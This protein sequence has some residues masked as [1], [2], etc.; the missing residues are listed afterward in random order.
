MDW[1]KRSTMNYGTVEYE[2]RLSRWVIQCA[3]HVAIRLKRVFGKIDKR[4]HDRFSLS[5]T[6]ENTRDLEWFV[7]RY[8]MDVRHPDRLRLL[9]DEHRE[10]QSLVDALLAKRGAIP[11]FELALPLRDYQ[12]IA[13]SLLLTNQYLLLA[14]EVGLG[15]TAAAIGT[16]ADKRT[17]P[18]LV[19]TLTHLPIQWRD[20]IARFAPNLTVHIVKKGQPYDIATWGTRRKRDQPELALFPDVVIINYH[21]LSGWA[22]T[23]APLVNSI[24]FDECQE[25]R[26]SDS[27][28]Y[29]AA[30]HI[31]DACDF[32]MGLSATPIYNYGGE[33]WNVTRC[34][35][36]DALG[37][38]DEFINEWC[39][40]AA[41]GSRPDQVKIKNPL[42][43]GAYTRESGIM[44]RR[45]RHDVG[46]ELPSI[47][48]VPYM[49]EAD[50]EALNSVSFSCAE[51]AKIVLAQGEG[52]RGQKM[53]ASEELS[54]KLRQA[55][56][57]A[58]APYVAEFVRLLV[59]SGEQIVL[60][61]WHREVYGIW[62][63]R[64]KDL[65]PV[66]Y[67]GSETPV[68]KEESK[69]KFID[70]ESKVLIISLRAG[71]GLDGLQKACRTVVF[72]ELD[73]SPGVHEQCLGRVA[74]D[75]QN[76]PVIAY[77]LIS[78]SG[79]DPIMVDV[80]GIKKQQVDGVK[81]DSVE[82]IEHLQSDGGHIRRLAEEFLRTRG[83][84]M[85]K[86]EA[87]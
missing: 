21:K 16:F 75:G 18:A 14:D 15:K 78:E 22:D 29:T 33:F 68:Q 77:F 80:L 39:S 49:I 73:W 87:A 82:L 53:H 36:P 45:T 5:A 56:G 63:D 3:P 17:L 35:A 86:E 40:A 58:K 67:T 37:T 46:R 2:P 6:P 31:A 64:L 30:R 69:R 52:Y 55:T 4:S 54:N 34:I 47:S 76:D 60:Y 27:N 23:L 1:I 8:P 43:F 79:A 48:T 25:L 66:L 61:G 19:V 65:N 71:A 26:K 51:L 83:G 10:R 81:A 85:S 42:A 72:G 41:F 7:S 50:P 44:L 9:A 74:R 38:R 12:R 24:V 59:E 32:R 84:P 70:G 62:L 57:I 20:E 28:K 11:E 13:A